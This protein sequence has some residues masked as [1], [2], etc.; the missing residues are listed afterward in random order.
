MCALGPWLA[1]DRDNTPVDGSNPMKR[2]A[3]LFLLGIAMLAPTMI[4]G[5]GEEPAKKDEPAK[6][7]EKPAGGEEKPKAN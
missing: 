6:A 5:C 4:V 3:T 1:K 2:L 7:P